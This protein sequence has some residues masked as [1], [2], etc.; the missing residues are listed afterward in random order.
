VFEY[1]QLKT[2]FQMNFT[3]FGLASSI[4]YIRFTE[5]NFS[6]GVWAVY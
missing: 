3:P 6:V 1:T 2:I 5:H 4:L